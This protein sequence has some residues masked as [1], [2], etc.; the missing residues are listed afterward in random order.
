[1]NSFTFE[2]QAS[3]VVFGPGSVA[4]LSV[5]LERLGVQRVLLVSTEGRSAMAEKV[6]SLAGGR[7][8]ENFDQAAPHVPEH[9]ARAARES[10]A[11]SRAD[12]IVAVGGS[13]A[14]GVAKSIAIATPLPI[15]AIPTT[16]GGSEMTPIW[17]LTRDGRKET[18][19]NPRVQPRVVIYDPDLTH[20]LPARVTASSGM[21]AL[22]H[23]I[24]ALYAPDRNPLTSAAAMEGIR[25]LSGALPLLV[26][27]P[28]D[29]EQRALALNG[30]WLAGFA[31]GT[32][33]MGLHHKLCHTIGGTYDLSHADTHAVLLPFTSAYNREFAPEAMRSAAVALGVVDA[34]TELLALSTAIDAPKSLRELG[35]RASDLDS[36]AALATERAYPNPRPVTLG[37][38]RELLA[39]AYEGEMDYVALKA[40]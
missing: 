4:E 16:Y 6:S 19:R 40:P 39:A 27:N 10:A 35:M 34:P 32:S 38:V 12:C 14:I 18:G 21:N 15:V 23:C 25:L 17:G 28:A 7:V 26:P 20:G 36:A 22:A 13:S 29:R 30:A 37:E 2:S 24:E 1:M 31:L 9:I 8:V 33:Q 11:S 5:E 3:R